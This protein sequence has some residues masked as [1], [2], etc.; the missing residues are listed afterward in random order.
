[1]PQHAERLPQNLDVLIVKAISLGGI[2]PYGMLLRS[3]ATT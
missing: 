2:R 3:G 1:V